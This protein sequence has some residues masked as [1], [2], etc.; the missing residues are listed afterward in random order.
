[1]LDQTI[2]SVDDTF[3]T[4][5]LQSFFLEE[6]H[7]NFFINYFFNPPFKILFG[8]RSTLLFKLTSEKLTNEGLSS[9]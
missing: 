3:S 6:K 2:N 4:V 7:T 8:F 5:S 1:M 9:K